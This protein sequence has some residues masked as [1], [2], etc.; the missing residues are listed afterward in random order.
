MGM[1]GRQNTKF[2][3]GV[4]MLTLSLVQSFIPWQ[5]IWKTQ[6]CCSTGSLNLGENEGLHLVKEKRQNCYAND[7]GRNTRLRV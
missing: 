6:I 5:G 7:R 2:S 1:G 4:L 3:K